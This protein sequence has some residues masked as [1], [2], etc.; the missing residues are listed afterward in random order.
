MLDYND[1]DPSQ[2]NLRFSWV[3][4]TIEN[5]KLDFAIDGKPRIKIIISY[6]IV[7][8]LKNENLA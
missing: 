3:V 5:L 2:L 7:T 1:T 8:K 4:V 6:L